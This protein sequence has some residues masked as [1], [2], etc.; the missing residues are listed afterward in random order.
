MKKT[1]TQLTPDR[2]REELLT[3]KDFDGVTG[4]LTITPDRQVQRP[5]HVLRWHNGAVTLVKTFGP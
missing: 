4:P 2:V 3:T 5:L 1:P